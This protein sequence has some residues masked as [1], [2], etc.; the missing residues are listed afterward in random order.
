MSPPTDDLQALTAAARRG[1]SRGGLP[2]AS[3]GP[4]G[5]ALAQVDRET[6]EATLLARAALAG[7]YAQAGRAPS[8]PS[9]PAPQFV[10]AGP[11]APPV[12]DALDGLLPALTQAPEVLREALSLLAPTGKRLNAVQARPLLALNDS[13]ADPLRGTLWPALGEHARWL[14]RLHPVW[15]RQDPDTPPP[16]IQLSR[17]RRELVDAHAADPGTVAADLTARWPSL[18]ADERRVA[19]NAVAGSLHPADLPVVQLA[20]NDKLP[21][22]RRQARLLQGHL[23]GEVQDAVRAALPTW[24]RRERGRAKLLRGEYVAALGEVDTGTTADNE[25]G[26]LLG[27][28]P[29]AELPGLLGLR[30]PE[31]RTAIAR[32]PAHLDQSANVYRGQRVTADLERGALAGAD[33]E[34][35][36]GFESGLGDVLEF[37][38]QDRVGALLWAA[39]A[40][41]LEQ[42]EPEE[43]L[44]RLTLQLFGALEAG[45]PPAPPEEPKPG[46][47]ARV[48][49]VLGAGPR[50]AEVSWPTRLHTLAEHLLAALGREVSGYLVLLL[51]QALALHLDPA[52]PG[53]SGPLP[54]PPPELPEGASKQQQER[55]AVARARYNQQLRARAD[56]DHIL[57]LRRQVRAALAEEA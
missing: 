26:R 7:L 8:L 32:F 48:I 54:V 28:L 43:K 22:L 18:K 11:M 9:V 37:W 31:I 21:D 47:L 19:L 51:V 57:T 29:L 52:R 39:T 40:R 2:G 3:A 17:L 6:P 12:P 10:A 36:L 56:L 42:A 24:F 46:L 14:A 53:P 34:T 16:S 33:L 55:Q 35:L 30:L 4:L 13:G 45:S 50:A 23:P 27:A 1:T 49:S 41:L 38:P 15:K 25:L 20:M 5:Q 44:L